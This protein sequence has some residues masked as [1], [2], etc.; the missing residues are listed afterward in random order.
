MKFLAESSKLAILCVGNDL[1]GDDSAGI[2][3]YEELVKKLSKNESSNYFVLF[4]GGSLPENY[5]KPIR[6]SRAS[7]MLLIDAAEFGGKPGDVG[8]F[9][10]DDITG[11]SYSTHTLPLSIFLKTLAKAT[12]TRFSIIGIQ[13]GR[14]E[15]GEPPDDIIVTT[16][17]IVAKELLKAIETI[18]DQIQSRM[19]K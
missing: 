11:S 17:K 15:L 5:T 16:S 3:V 9:S 6:E 7:H 19:N 13:P 1:R 4:N 18:E 2:L 14:T 8:L 10:P 12:E